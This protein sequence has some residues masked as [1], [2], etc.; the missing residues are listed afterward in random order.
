MLVGAVADHERDAIIGKR[1]NSADCQRGCGH[2]R[3][4]SSTHEPLLHQV[5]PRQAYYDAPDK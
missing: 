3:Q 2:S 4:R 1:R 5:A